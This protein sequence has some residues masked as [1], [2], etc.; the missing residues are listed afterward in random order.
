[1][2]LHKT[3]DLTG[4]YPNSIF[5]S[6]P[7]HSIAVPFIHNLVTVKCFYTRERVVLVIIHIIYLPLHQAPVFIVI[8][9]MHNLISVKFCYSRQRGL[10]YN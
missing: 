4:N 9:F 8:S 5:D 7:G 10:V 3:G 2:L 1:V 6:A